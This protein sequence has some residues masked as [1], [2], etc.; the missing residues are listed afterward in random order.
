LDKQ[1]LE[2]PGAFEYGCAQAIAG[3]L[4]QQAHAPQTF[5]WPTRSGGSSIETRERKRDE[6]LTRLEPLPMKFRETVELAQQG[7]KLY[8][9]VEFF[10]ME[11]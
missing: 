5:R 7:D 4:S 6:F 3:A 9:R 10:L 8:Q 1:D 11:Y 2:F